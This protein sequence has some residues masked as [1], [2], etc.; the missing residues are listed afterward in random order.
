MQFEIDGARSEV[1]VELAGPEAELKDHRIPLEQGQGARLGP[2]VD[3][4]RRQPGRQRLLVR[5]RAA[6]CRGRRSSSPRT[7]RRPGR[8]SWPRRS[9]PIRRSQCSA[10]VARAGPARRRRLG[11]RS[12]CCC[13]RRR[14][15]S[16]TRPR[17]IQA[18]VERGGSAIFFPPRGPD[19]D[20]LFGVR[21]T[22]WQEPKA[23][24]P[25]R[26]LARRSGP[27]GPHPERRAAAGRAAPGPAV[28][29]PLGRRADGAGDAQGRRAAA[30]AGRRP[31]GGAAYFCATT[32][33]SGDSSL[34]T[35][36]VVLYVM[37]QRA[38]AAGAA[39]LGTTR[40]LTAGEP[41][42]RR[43]RHAGSGSPAATRRS[44]PNTRPTAASMRPATGCW[45]STVGGARNRP[46]VLAD[47]RVDDL[48]RGLDFA[49][50][51][52]RAGS[53]QLAD[54][55]D[56][57]DVPDRHDRRA[58]WSRPA[59]ACP[60]WPGPRRPRR[61]PEPHP[62]P[63][64]HHERHP[65][66]HIP[67]DTVDRGPLGRRRSWSRPAY[68]F[69]AWRRSGYRVAMGL[70]ELLRL[71]IVA[72]VAVLLNQP[73]WIEEFRPE[74]K[75]TIA[76]LWDASP[77][78][79]T[80]DVVRADQPTSSA[81]T[82][83]RGDRA[84]DRSR[85]VGQAATADE[86]RHPAVLVPDAARRTPRGPEDG[87]Q[88]ADPHGHGTDLYEPL[89]APGEDHQPARDRAGLRRRLERGPA[90]GAGRRPAAAQGRARSSPCRWAA[91]PDCPISS[92]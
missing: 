81:R 38:M 45:P 63:E 66:A 27:A 8:C 91:A 23:R 78:M 68:G 33:A 79:D 41:A 21:W 52:D 44:R 6:R 92:S 2:G 9:P 89:S 87:R 70:L 71:A 43:P 58:W 18:F 13:G 11:H 35:N 53:M 49:R 59:S 65:I 12:P 64:P 74:E 56:L 5:L 69:I 31:S 19:S 40:Q 39:S 55:G 14:C 36:G 54:P 46:P 7:P 62:S 88:D 34:A 30:G 24:G 90:A 75:P 80:R 15:P 83:T 60:S 28:L 85:V 84:A 16:R 86:R 1:A 17:A 73:E 26:R 4:G 25:G 57:A 22:S 67:L 10:E 72:L 29:R 42:A 32:P 76:V 48:F 51:D 47:R 61:S 77:S 50:V 3:P 82:R 20:E 37:V